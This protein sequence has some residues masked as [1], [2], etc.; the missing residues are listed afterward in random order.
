MTKSRIARIAALTAGSVAAFSFAVSASAMTVA[1]IQAAIAT[2]SQQL[3]A[4]Q[5]GS[6]ASVTFTRDLTVGSKGA[7]VTALQS[8]L[9]SKSYSIPAGATG[10]FGAQTKAAV[11]AWQAASGISPAAGYFGPKSRAYVGAGAVVVV[12]GGTTTGGVTTGTGSTGGITTPGAEGTL[13]VTAG[14]VS[15]STVY[16]G[17]SMA[18]VLAFKAKALNSDIAIQRVKIDLGTN[19]AIYNKVYSKIY[20]VDESGRTV[21]SA[22]LNSN[23]VVKD[24]DNIYY[25][26]LSGFSSVVPK[27]TTKNFTVKVDVRTVSSGSSDLT[28]HTVRLAANGVRGQD[29][30][31][32]DQYS[33]ANAT[34]VS[35]AV[36]LAATLAD[37]ATLTLATAASTPVTQEIVAANGS[38]LNEADKVSLLSFDVRATND[39]VL[40][41]D[42]VATIA[43][44]GS[45]NASS[46]YLY[47]GNTLVGSAGAS[48]GTATFNDVN[49]TVPRG[50]TVTFTLKADVRSASTAQTTFSA[51]VASN[52][53][54][55]ENSNGDNVSTTG[56]ATSNNTYVRKVGPVFS[57]N[58]TP[59]IVKSATASQNNQSTST[60]T[61]TFNV[62]ITAVGGDIYFGKQAASSTFGVA[63][64]FNG[65]YNDVAGQTGASTTSFAT[66][67]SGVVTTGINSTTA[68]KLAQN[69]S[70][71]IPVTFVSEG[72]TTAG[73][74]LTTGNYAVGLEY[75]KWST[76]DVT[77][78]ISRFMGGKTEWRTAAVQ[79]P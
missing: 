66:P 14:T 40:V 74:L 6:S 64:Y 62:H 41:T 39:D 34:D 70:I 71:D 47:A 55:A 18:P 36:T 49:Y 16:S 26:T 77:M 60:V 37:S 10:T 28:S 32:I 20:L 46:T 67:T 7:D 19:S 15:N 8:W 79:L 76:D 25:I 13:T 56:S 61:A 35:K 42:V 57:L 12:P 44:I 11:S 31:G 54:T 63:T 75:I 72:R 1:E 27:D 45:A 73:A 50:S 23:T 51:S 59:S 22:D 30:A 69:N 48:V 33:P 17:S 43:S 53:I 38:A 68:F 3:A 2:L 9:I 65:V 29:G 52:G 78:Q 58:G 4:M 5:G 24:S 21:A